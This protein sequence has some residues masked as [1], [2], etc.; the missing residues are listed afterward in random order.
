MSTRLGVEEHVAAVYPLCED[1]YDH[2]FQKD[3]FQIKLGFNGFHHYFP[4]V[5]RGVMQFLDAYNSVHYFTRNA[6]EGL[7]N[8]SVPRDTNFQKLVHI[9][10]EGYVPGR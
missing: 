5:P 2:N 4:M 7:K 3:Y 8:L 10:Y 1:D 9:A 6:R